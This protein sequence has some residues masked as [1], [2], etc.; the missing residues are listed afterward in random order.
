MISHLERLEQKHGRQFSVS[1]SNCCFDLVALKKLLLLHEMKD[2]THEVRQESKWFRTLAN[3]VTQ[4][5]GTPEV[6]P[7]L[8]STFCSMLQ[9]KSDDYF[10]PNIQLKT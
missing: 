3:S 5:H 4:P 7:A 8:V 1:L 6:N 2:I 9:D 10:W